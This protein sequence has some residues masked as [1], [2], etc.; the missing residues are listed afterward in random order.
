[1]ADGN[2][3][4]LWSVPVKVFYWHA[5]EGSTGGLITCQSAYLLS[6]R[7][8][9]THKALVGII[10]EYILNVG[11]SLSSGWWSIWVILYLTS[12]SIKWRR[13][14]LSRYGTNPTADSC[15]SG[16]SILDKVL[17]PHWKGATSCCSQSHLTGLTWTQITTLPCRCNVSYVKMF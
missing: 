15:C 11:Y 3:S 13:V 5:E 16:T 17:E 9:L 2:K 4:C 10:I 7:T 1:M 6:H 8:T 12:A 14:R